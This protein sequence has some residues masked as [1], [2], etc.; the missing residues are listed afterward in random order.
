MIDTNGS[1]DIYLREQPHHVF[2]DGEAIN[3][4]NGGSGAIG[5]VFRVHHHTAHARSSSGSPLYRLENKKLVGR[6]NLKF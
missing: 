3:E 2:Q 6:G 5:R 4:F 1:Q